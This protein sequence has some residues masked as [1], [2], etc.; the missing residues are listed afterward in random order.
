MNNQKIK[1]PHLYK[2]KPRKC[3]RC[4]ITSVTVNKSLRYNS[5]LCIDCLKEIILEDSL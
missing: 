2:D 1:D 5:L 4:N 3:S